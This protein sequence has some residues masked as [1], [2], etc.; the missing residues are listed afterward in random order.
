MLTGSTPPPL[1]VRTHHKFRKIL[2]FCTKNCG[3]PQLNKPLSPDCEHLLCT[4][5]KTFFISATTAYLRLHQIHQAGIPPA[6]RLQIAVFERRKILVLLDQNSTA[7]LLRNSLKWRQN[8][9][10]KTDSSNTID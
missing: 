8:E 4:A 7:I 3:R 10:N 2:S 5:P 6:I 9:I 1:F